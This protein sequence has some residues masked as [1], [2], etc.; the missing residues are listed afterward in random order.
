MNWKCDKVSENMLRPAR[1]LEEYQL[2]EAAL[3]WSLA[4]CIVIQ[5]PA[6]I[7]SRANWRDGLKPYHHQVQNLLTFC[8]RLPVTLLADD[9]G[10]GKT[11]SAGLILS[12][13]MVRKRVSRALILCP[14]ILCSQWVDE[15]QSK[16]GI[17]GRA[18]SGGQLDAELN[19]QVPVVVTTYES[20][21]DRFAEIKPGEFDILILDEAHR[22]RNLHGGN[23]PPKM[24]TAVRDA[25]ERRLFKFVVM[26]TATPIQNR[27]W[28]LYSLL[29]CLAVAKGHKNP[30][31]SPE[32]FKQLFLL[33]GSEG[34]RLNPSNAEA[35]RRVLRQYVVRTR[36][37]DANLQFPTR[38]VRLVRVDLSPQE[39]ELSRV[40]ADHVA[41]LNALQ[42]TS[43]AQA[44]MSS[45]NAL[46]AQLENM[47]MKDASLKM[48]ARKARELANACVMPAKLLR[49]LLLCDEL[50]A[51][52]PEDWRIVV[53]T[54][55][56]ETQDAI[57]QALI[58]K[59]IPFGFIRGGEA[60]QNQLSIERLRESPPGLNVLVSTDAGAEGVNLQA[61]NVLVNYDLP[62]NPMIVEQRIGR[63]Q[64]L[65]SKHD[66]VIICNLVA[67]DSVEERVVARL[68]EKL[69][70]IAQAIGDI[71]SILESPEWD[72]DE[73]RFENQ[74][75]DLVVK[76][77]LGHD[78]EQA[79]RLVQQSI[80][81]ARKVIEEQRVEIDRT[82]G[83]L[84]ELHYIGP[85]MP[86]LKR[87][88][89]TIPAR[90]F[91]L[92]AKRAEGYVVAETSSGAFE[93]KSDGKLSEV[94][95]FDEAVAESLSSQA[96]FMGKVRLYQQ[97]KTAFERL[98]QH[99]LDR[100]GHHLCDL[101]PRTTI[102]SERFA[103]S[104]CE[105]IPEVQFL[106]S[107]IAAQESKFQGRV[108]VKAKASNGVDAFEKLISEEFNPTGHVRI[109][110]SA[111]TFSVAPGEASLSQV[112]PNASV[113]LATI[114]AA[115]QDLG[116][117]C[118]FYEERRQSE[119][120]AA[121]DDLR[122]RHKVNEDFNPSVAGEIVG[123]Q[124]FRY[125]EVSL[126]VQFSVQGEGRYEASLRAVPSSGQLIAEPARKQCEET[127]INVPISCLQMC[128]VTNKLVL[129]HLL[130]TSESS[131]RRGLR[132]RIVTCEV[133]G[134]KAF[135][136][137]VA[138][139]SVSNTI[140]L[141]SSLV[142][143]QET[144]SLILPVEAGT[145]AV[146]GKVARKDLL[147]ASSKAPHRLGIASEFGVC[148]VTRNRLLIDEMGQSAVTGK[149][150]D[151]SLLV[152]CAVTGKAALPA[153]LK[154]C[155][156]TGAL[157]IPNEIA[158]CAVTGKHALRSLM[159]VCRQTNQQILA[160][161]AATSDY[162]GKMVLRSLLQQSQKPPGR[163]GI[164]DE[165]GK[166]EITKTR[167]LLDELGRS[168]VSKKLID[169]TLLHKSA[170]SGAMALLTEMVICQ[171]SGGKFLPG[172]VGHCSVTGKVVDARLL[173]KNDLSGAAVLTNLTQ[174]CSVTGKRVLAEQLER[175][176]LTNDWALPSE[177]RTCAV[178]G[179]RGRR[180]RMLRSA[181]SKKYVVP[182]AAI[183]SAVSDGVGLP[184]EVVKCA[185]LEKEILSTET[186]S[187]SLTGEDFAAS[188][189]NE[190]DELKALRNMLDGRMHDAVQAD[191]L[192]RDIQALDLQFFSGLKS[193]WVSRSP[194][195]GKLAV[196]CELHS[197]MGWKVRFAGFL[198]E[199]NPL[200]IT[201]Q[202]VLGYRSGGS[203]E[204][205][206]EVE[207]S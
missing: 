56:K 89:P 128:Q 207:F 50:K 187:C 114:V 166:C 36:R 185:W 98:V 154:K 95:A 67:S 118:R 127:K 191:H 62:W 156:V 131:G 120:K 163:R 124:G 28:D 84:D 96:V 201:G 139:S 7:Q 173:S 102:G 37:G 141:L 5:T 38:V 133:T 157:V 150:V 26:L 196:C 111:G 57:G 182:Q 151:R 125:D 4:D 59:D 122:L 64:R 105:T 199:T 161:E 58:S 13:L 27:I 53:F 3:E 33:P 79:A 6:D 162:S 184:T 73:D 153:E 180:D 77:L 132:N 82:L 112:L 11:I 46:A 121:G 176:T 113:S 91:V 94:I 202:G 15:M 99:W 14:K 189:L 198:V 86:K 70:G 68:M 43:L 51:E 55:R 69:Q 158:T 63:L 134:K 48:A 138:R 183:R 31:G 18:V 42:Q 167:L 117:F 47:A 140:C 74:I 101:R 92:R 137:E 148:D 104:W 32:E 195:G 23:K 123:F 152:H 155:D 76:S 179:K 61:A 119:L 60:K 25:L 49:L 97:G 72:G 186:K 80:E 8:R 1:T 129:S 147:S 81:Q 22:L 78:V 200:K 136:D 142:K 45:P 10:L 205:E 17:E 115:D 108:D 12:E 164:A 192:I 188:L 144:G 203:W 87:V 170:S 143:C 168:A 178:T 160:S 20:A 177:L 40:V 116:E 88:E 54:Q 100:C 106:S 29:D 34:R 169:K 193:V 109:N 171:E 135:S 181:V 21:A 197:W 24:A 103:R 2:H 174:K 85:S 146:S 126:I 66:S 107:K 39:K 41:N 90:D 30:L 149:L 52:R 75:R 175:C 190:D 172:E 110:P 65:A 206:Y 35:F 159:V 19:A 130:V 9:V 83:N 16:F 204:L 93:V 165:F 194:R 44:M 145:S 71:E